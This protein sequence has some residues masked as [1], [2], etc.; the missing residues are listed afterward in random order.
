MKTSPPDRAQIEAFVSLQIAK[1]VASRQG[2]PIDQV[3]ASLKPTT[4]LL[5]EKGSVVELDSLDALDLIS[6]VEK[7][8]SVIFPDDTEVSSISTVSDIVDVTQR[9]LAAL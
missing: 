7:E 8:Y 9:S 1:L 4:N 2:Q 6:V 5:G 3:L